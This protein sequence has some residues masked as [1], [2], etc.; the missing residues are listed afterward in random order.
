MTESLQ[1]LKEFYWA[2]RET[3]RLAGAGLLFV[4]AQLIVLLWTLRR[5]RELS[6]IRERMSRLADGL[7]LLTDT[8]EAGFATV[9]RQIEQ[10]AR[11]AAPPKPS[12]AAV[13][14]R[15]ANA[16][17]RGERVEKIAAN[18]SLSES[19]VHLHLAMTANQPHQA[20]QTTSD[21]PLAPAS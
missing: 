5:L 10:L 16:A 19:E 1:D 20:H 8:T 12:R 2:H 18:E 17:R 11:N 7:A 4:C 21:T 15:V 6:H 9:A 3:F 13:A 14:K